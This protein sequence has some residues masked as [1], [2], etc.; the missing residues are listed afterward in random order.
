MT[1]H[2][3]FAPLL[4]VLFGCAVWPVGNDPK[5]EDF[6]RQA[7]ELVEAIIKFKAKNGGLPPSLNALVP[8]YIGELPEV[9]KHSLYSPGKETFMYDYSPSWPQAGRTSCATQIGSGK[10]SCQGY[11]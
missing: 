11:I 8:A 6:R 10:W 4:F 9:S 1:K 3:Y 2:L 5:G 7:T